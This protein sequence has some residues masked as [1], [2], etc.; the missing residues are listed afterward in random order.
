MNCD[1]IDK[2]ILLALIFTVLGDALALVA[3]LLSQDCD[4]KNEIEN[5]NAEQA[6]LARISEL[7]QRVAKLENS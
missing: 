3:E 2:L 4:R 7:E 5:I 6:L 1:D